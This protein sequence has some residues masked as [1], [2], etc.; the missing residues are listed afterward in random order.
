MSSHM[1][2]VTSYKEQIVKELHAQDCLTENS[3]HALGPSR[4]STAMREPTASTEQRH[5]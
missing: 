5:L 3:A 4:V 1:R 2:T